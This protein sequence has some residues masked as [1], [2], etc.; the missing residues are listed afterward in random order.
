M[1]ICLTNLTIS[2]LN[3]DGKD[4]CRTEKTTF[5]MFAGIPYYIAQRD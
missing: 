4:E 5:V 1:P 3:P 2:G